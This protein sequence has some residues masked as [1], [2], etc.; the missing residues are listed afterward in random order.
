MIFTPNQKRQEQLPNFGLQL[1]AGKDPGAGFGKGLYGD[2]Q[3][4]MPSAYLK[5]RDRRAKQ[6]ETIGKDGCWVHYVEGDRNDLKDSQYFWG[7]AAITKSSKDDPHTDLHTDTKAKALYALESIL[8]DVA[9]LNLPDS[10]ITL[11]ISSHN[12]D[13][14]AD[15][16]KRNVEGVHRFEHLTPMREKVT[17]TVSLRIADIYPE[18]FGSI[19]YCLFGG[20]PQLAL[21]PD[22]IAIGL[23][24]GTSTTIISVF[25]GAG[26]LKAR[27]VIES[28]S[29]SLYGAIA[30]EMNRQ[31][32]A[33][34]RLS[35]DVNHSVDNIRKGVEAFATKQKFVYGQSELVGKPF[36][37]EYAEY[38][39]NWFET[40]VEQI[41]DYI[42]GQGFLDKAKYLAAW[43]GGVL[44]PKMNQA[45]AE[46]NVVCL[47]DPQFIN[48][49]GLKLLA[50]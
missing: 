32:S 34:N 10:E 17:K 15:T 19:A 24:W 41:G 49:K 47:D 37:K 4:I 36:D 45:L 7:T 46:F 50:E 5:V 30:D 25:D 39:Q 3:V 12:P 9:V 22:E 18:G 48:A 6:H 35:R 2:H 21:E 27:K 26:S 11:A 8:A 43:G 20:E 38:F 14:W 29:S 16:I 42:S 44:L 28:G 40:R 1:A 31:N 33:A 13:K 23:D